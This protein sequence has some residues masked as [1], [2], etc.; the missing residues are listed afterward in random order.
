MKNFGVTFDP[1]FWFDQR[2]KDVNRIAFFHLYY[3]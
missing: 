3:S 1:A 2:I